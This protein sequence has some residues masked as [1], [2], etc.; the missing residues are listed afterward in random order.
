MKTFATK[1]HQRLNN[2]RQ[3]GATPQA[4]VTNARTSLNPP[5]LAHPAKL[6]V[7]AVNDPLEREADRVANQ[8]MR[9]GGGIGFGRE[10]WKRENHG[11]RRRCCQTNAETLQV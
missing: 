11:N 5:L 7:G 10:N 4:R 9:R 2:I 3:P 1:Q 6:K 8:V